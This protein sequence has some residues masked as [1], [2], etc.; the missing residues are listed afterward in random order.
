MDIGG[1]PLV[2]ES[3][4]KHLIAFKIWTVVFHIEKYKIGALVQILDTIHFII[5]HAYLFTRGQSNM[6]WFIYERSA[7]NIHFTFHFSFFDFFLMFFFNF[8][9]MQLTNKQK[10]NRTSFP[11]VL[12]LS[13]AP[14]LSE[15]IHQLCKATI[16]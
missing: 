15:T 3:S 16:R 11:L 9:L 12:I 6:R 7:T 14:F 1:W 8:S 5:F 13:K 10:E 4:R 2:N